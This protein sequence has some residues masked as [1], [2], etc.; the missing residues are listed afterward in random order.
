[1]Q[2][3]LGVFAGV[4]LLA[5][6]C[7]GSDSTPTATPTGNVGAAPSAPATEPTAT[8]STPAASPT[9]TPW[10][11]FV[12]VVEGEP[13]PLPDGVV[14]YYYG[15]VFTEGIPADRWLRAHQTEDGLVIR[16]LSEGL[17]AGSN[18]YQ[19]ISAPKDGRL[20]TTICVQ[21]Y[22][23]GHADPSA[24]AREETYESL[25]GGITWHRSNE[26]P[27]LVLPDGV[28]LG[29]VM[30]DGTTVAGTYDSAEQQYDWFT[31]PGRT[32]VESPVGNARAGMRDGQFVWQT[33]SF[34][35]PSRGGALYDEDGDLVLAEMQPP[36][37]GAYDVQRWWEFDLAVW[38]PFPRDT[39]TTG[40]LT[41]IAADGSLLRT[42]R[43]EGY[44]I[45]PVGWRDDDH[46]IVLRFYPEE[47][48]IAQSYILAFET[49]EMNRIEGLQPTEQ[50]RDVYATEVMT[51]EFAMV[52]APDSCLHVR[53]ETNLDSESL[54][55]FADGVL[56]KVLGDHGT[57]DWL[58]V[59]A[60]G[61]VEGFAS[62]V[63][64]LR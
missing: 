29:G 60:P 8:T 14:L 7:G 41:D 12:E 50:D 46:L 17:P 57:T 3:L 59:L 22:C 19:F 51:G 24:D 52:D 33:V 34:D 28:F 54:G 5:V 9:A 40:Y 49:G 23:G 58:P 48:S 63:F 36:M 4:A 16:D 39:A 45:R 42:V 64:L 43:W 1:M 27:G 11:D 44:D 15:Y 10:D 62:T 32:T 61:G 20:F 37:D 21:G 47:G 55:C 30:S 26:P 31:W 6:A 13:V 56:L 2:W 18:G 25:D 38:Y 35:F 53:A